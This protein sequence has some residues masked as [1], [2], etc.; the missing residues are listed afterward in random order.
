[1]NL[2]QNNFVEEKMLFGTEM[3]ENGNKMEVTEK[4]K[5]ILCLEYRN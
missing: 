4:K 3:T 2:K 5:K 1:M